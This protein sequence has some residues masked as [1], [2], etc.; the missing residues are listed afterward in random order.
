LLEYLFQFFR[1]FTQQILLKIEFT[2]KIWAHLIREL[3]KLVFSK[4]AR[5]NIDRACIVCE[6]LN[7]IASNIEV[8]VLEVQIT[9]ICWGLNIALLSFAARMLKVLS[10]SIIDL[11]GVVDATCYSERGDCQ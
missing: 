6:S 10:K 9:Q 8:A 11:E 1:I 7:T 2:Q 3:G 4:I 5:D